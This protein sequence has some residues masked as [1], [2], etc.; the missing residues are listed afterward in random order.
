[1]ADFEQDQTNPAVEGGLSGANVTVDSKGNVVTKGP[2][3]LTEASTKSI[4]NNMQQLIDRRTSPMSQFL[5]G[6]KDATAWTAGGV[7][8]PS[9]ALAVRD[10]QKDKEDQ[11]VMNMRSQMATMQSNA[12]QNAN[13]R[14]QL[15]MMNPSK[16]AG[17]GVQGGG[18]TGSPGSM[19]GN[20]PG[21]VYKMAMDMSQTDAQGARKYLAETMKDLAKVNASADMYK[22]S[23]PV[24]KW[25]GQKY[26]ADTI[27]PLQYREGLA[28][29]YYRSQDGVVVGGLPSQQG[30]GI[31]QPTSSGDAYL[32]KTATIESGG[33]PLA[34]S[35]TSSASG[36]Y[37]MTKGTFET[38]QAVDPR[39][40]DVTWEQFKNPSLIALPPPS[41]R[42]TILGRRRRGRQGGD[43]R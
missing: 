17:M 39:L 9:E 23:I 18:G 5:G 14:A 8:G 27:S 38:V 25:D 40:K 41:A 43:V 13:I 36:L 21:D 35:K 10:A 7:N 28:S 15:A 1:M 3:N 2:T 26:V 34:K 22:P 29:G 37:G 24:Q 31:K 4:L 11:S 32:D 12:E 20:I 19:Y 30:V 6:L 16:A 33:D 42:L